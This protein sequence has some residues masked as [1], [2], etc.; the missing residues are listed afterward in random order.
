VSAFRQELQS[1]ELRERLVQAASDEHRLHQRAGTERQLAGRWLERAELA[2]QRGLSE[3]AEEA[4]QRAARHA[5]RADDLEAAFERQRALVEQLRQAIRFPGALYQVSGSEASVLG[6]EADVER[7]LAQ[8]EREIGLERD[9][10]EL[11]SRRGKAAAAPEPNSTAPA[12][13]GERSTR[14]DPAQRGIV[15]EEWRTSDGTA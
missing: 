1:R 12:V 11:R 10:E 2:A 9:L 3:L 6:A 13:G 8:L 4:S 15:R 14:R 5:R 7:H